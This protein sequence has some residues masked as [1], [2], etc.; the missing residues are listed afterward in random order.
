MLGR[1]GVEGQQLG[2]GVLQQ[3]GDLGGMGAQLL[4]DLV[5]TAAGLGGGGGGED[6]ADRAR[7]QRLLRPGDVAE[8]VAQ[9]VDCAALPPAAKHL[10]DGGLQAGVR[11]GDAQLDAVQAMGPQRPQEL[12]PERLG[13]GLADVDADDLTAASLVDAVGDHQGLVADPTRLPHPLHLRVQP[14]VGVGTLQ[15]P[16]AEDPDLLV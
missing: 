4:D 15:G 3:A 1:E 2:L 8:H 13:L 6:P 12:P 16:L 7:D 5:E 10:R 11:I 9:E 14:Q